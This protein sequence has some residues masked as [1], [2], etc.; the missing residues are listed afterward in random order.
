MPDRPFWGTF[1]RRWNGW[2][3]GFPSTPD[4]LADST[5]LGMRLRALTGRVQDE[6]AGYEE[7]AGRG[8]TT[9]PADGRRSRV[10]S[11]MRCALT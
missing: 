9:T 3:S 6:L 1:G 8:P 4:S 11:P 10:R 5:S 2:G 7:F